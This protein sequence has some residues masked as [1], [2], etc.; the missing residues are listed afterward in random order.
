MNDWKKNFLNKQ[1]TERMSK[2]MNEQNKSTK[3]LELKTTESMN[4]IM[5]ERK[6]MNWFINE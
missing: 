3:K 1:I 2:F 6:N 4:C 5:N